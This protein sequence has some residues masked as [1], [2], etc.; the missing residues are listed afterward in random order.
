MYIQIQGQM[1]VCEDNWC[2]F[3]FNTFKSI[4]CERIY[5]DKEVVDE[6]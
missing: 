4:M 1:G 6:M 5:F 3:I 2:D